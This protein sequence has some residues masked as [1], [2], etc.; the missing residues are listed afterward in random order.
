[1]TDEKPITKRLII[2]GV[3]GVATWGSLIAVSLVLEY[4][5]N[6]PAPRGLHGMPPIP[7][8][9]ISALFLGWIP[10]IVVCVRKFR[11]IEKPMNKTS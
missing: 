11:R 6:P 3:F 5:F 9:F 2:P 7:A 1:M 10:A 8:I 4:L